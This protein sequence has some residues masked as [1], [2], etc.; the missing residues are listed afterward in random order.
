MLRNIFFYLCFLPATLVL[1]S[2]TVLAAVDKRGRLAHKVGLVWGRTTAFLTGMKL[3]ADLRTLETGRNYIFMVNHQ[4]QIDIPVLYAALK[5]FRFG[6]VA[7]HSL[8]KIPIFGRAMK[9]AGHIPLDRTNRRRAMKSIDYAVSRAEQGWSIVIFPEGT[10]STDFSKLQEFKIGGMIM[11]LKC[12][13]PVA[14]LIVAGTGA[15]LPRGKLLLKPG[16]V[17]VKALV[18]IETQGK[19]TLKE[20]EQF[21]QDLYAVMHAAYSEMIND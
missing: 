14:P 7:K 17:R 20:R 15:M 9:N 13:L 4:S 10:R 11:A 8:F 16:R 5:S 21:K 18:P 1:S 2:L 6:F 19:Y 12:G 3:D